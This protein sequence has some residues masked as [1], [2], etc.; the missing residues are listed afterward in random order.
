M[1]PDDAGEKS[2]APTPRRR[3]EARD[4]GQAAKSQDLT[5][6]VALLGAMVIL[7]FAA[8]GMLRNFV[9]LTQAM[10]GYQGSDAVTR[11]SMAPLALLAASVLAKTAAPVCIAFMLVAVLA[12]LAQVGLLFSF[13]PITPKLSKI[14]PIAG[15]GKVFSMQSL[16]RLFT[17][18]FK[19]ILIGAV[20]FLT[21]RSWIAQIINMSSLDY[22][23]IV[24]LAGELVFTLG[25]RLA[26]V[27]LVIAIIDYIYQRYRHEQGL[28]MTKH[29]V[30]EELRRME[31]DPLV[32]ERRKRVARQLA[33][34][35]MQ[36]AVP[37]A[38]V[39]VTN[40]TELAIAIKYDPDTMA[41]PKVVAKGAELIAKRIRELAVAH[42]VPIVQRK[43]LAQ[44]LYRTVDVGQEIPP[45]LY[46][47][48][49][50]ILAYVYELSG[51]TLSNT[52]TV[53]AGA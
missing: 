1:P 4:Q 32:R 28:R 43:P 2:E 34:Q 35:R 16:M 31:G 51:K 25:I 22:L 17:S 23:A 3:Q 46:K 41:A 11:D 30:K 19:V 9:N 12:T 21:I 39:V 38:D 13:D 18:L 49:A 33:T 48:V 20:A 52:Q 8:P 26:L 6:A 5:A 47:A 53:P 44:T 42:A 29:A 37:N 45:A 50:E 14:D 36:A 15:M 24:G 27:L 7:N 40:P 10:L